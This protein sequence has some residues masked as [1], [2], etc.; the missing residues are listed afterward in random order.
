MPPTFRDLGVPADLAAVLDQRGIAAPFPV[1]AATLPD[2]LAGRDIA[3]K[4][5]TGSG[6]T[7]AFGIPLVVRATHGRPRRPHTL[8]LA[9]T[10]ELAAQIE[11]E[12]RPLAAVRGLTV[13]AFYGG[14]G[15]GKQLTALRKGVDIAVACPG[16]LADLVQRR[17]CRLDEVDLVVIDEADRMADMGF[18]P[19]VRRLLDQVRPDRQTLL[20]SATLDDDVALLVRHYQQDPA[21]HE[22]G[23]IDQGPDRTEHHFWHAR[24]DERVDLTARLVRHHGPTIVFCRTKRRADRVTRQLDKAGVSAAAIHGDRSQAQRERALDAFTRGKVEALVATDVAA[25]GI[26]VTDVACV[27]HYD[28]PGD[29][30]DYVHRSGRTGRA[31]ATGTVISLVGGEHRKAATRIQRTL[32][33]DTATVQPDLTAMAVLV[34]PVPGQRS[35]SHLDAAPARKPRP[36][37][38]GAR[39]YGDRDRD[40]P[41]TGGPHRNGG[42][43]GSKPYGKPGRP[44]TG[45]RAGGP[46]NGSSSYG[47]SANASSNGANGSNGGPRNGAGPRPKNRSG[48]PGGSGGAGGPG[49]SRKPGGHRKGGPRPR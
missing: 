16:R 41:R 40:R 36:D 11:G 14:V 25:R 10:R 8:V 35:E 4:A 15:F 37:Q 5:P 45:A 19:E 21:R 20:F 1:Q 13:A 42:K 24:D 22:V 18:L 34:A 44:K 33:L 30:K 27:I 29:D 47:G 46:S 23:A 39:S 3:G 49:G 12:L 43:P 26:H 32:K 38:G 2:A 7:L 6:K 17:E 31:G 48:R 9:P 28:L